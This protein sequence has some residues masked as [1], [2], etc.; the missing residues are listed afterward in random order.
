MLGVAM[1]EMRAIVLRLHGGEAEITPVGGNGC[2]HCASGNG[3]GSGKLSQLF[4]SSKPRTFMVANAIRAQVGD[5][6]NVGLPEGLLLRNSVLMYVLPLACMLGGSLLA[7]AIFKDVSD[8]VAL[9]GALAGLLAGFLG[10]RQ[11][12]K[13]SGMQAVVRSVVSAA[14]S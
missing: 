10:A 2:G 4:C 1:N 8:A 12:A 3:C 13:R 5:E 11:L 9:A 14:G 6:V 7:S